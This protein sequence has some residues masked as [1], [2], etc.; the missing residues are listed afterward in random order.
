MLYIVA[1]SCSYNGSAL[2][3]ARTLP[4]FDTHEDNILILSF[5]LR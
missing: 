2:V 5:C 3:C 1:S 4:E